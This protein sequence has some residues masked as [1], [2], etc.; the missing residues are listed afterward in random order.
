M[1]RGSLSR[2]QRVILFCSTSLPPHLPDWFSKS[3]F[4]KLP[5]QKAAA[6]APVDPSESWTSGQ[7]GGRRKRW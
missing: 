3:Q 5:P 4:L 2:G 7:Y 6:W 1:Q